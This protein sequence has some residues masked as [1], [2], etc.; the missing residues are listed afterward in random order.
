MAKLP[1]YTHLHGTAA[2]KAQYK[3]TAMYQIANTKKLK[4]LEAHSN[5]HP[6]GNFYLKY[7]KN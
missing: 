5:T 3:E 1:Y 2:A 6:D 7:L 4:D